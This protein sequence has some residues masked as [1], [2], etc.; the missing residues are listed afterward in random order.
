MRPERERSYSEK[1][2][3]LKGKLFPEN[4]Q[5]HLCTPECVTGV[6]KEEGASIDINAKS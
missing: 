6:L 2:L 3:F 5:E 1:K 4:A